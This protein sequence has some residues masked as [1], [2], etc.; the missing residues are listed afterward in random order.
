MGS[1]VVQVGP[2]RPRRAPPGSRCGSRLQVDVHVGAE[3]A[4]AMRRGG[5]RTGRTAFARMS[6]RE[7]PITSNGCNCTTADRA[8][9]GRGRPWCSSHHL[10]GQVRQRAA[11]LHGEVERRHQHVMAHLDVHHPACGASNGRGLAR[12]GGQNHHDREDR[13]SLHGPPPRNSAPIS[14][15]TN[16]PIHHP[17]ITQSTN[18]QSTNHPIHQSP[19]PPITQSTNHQ[20][21]I[22]QSPNHQ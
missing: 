9:T 6:A 11:R 10:A 19:N 14:P 16:P 2:V 3:G 12:Q 7:P 8:S 20:S 5:S 13:Q 22:T 1:S 15:I 18:H 4:F 17:P 21:P